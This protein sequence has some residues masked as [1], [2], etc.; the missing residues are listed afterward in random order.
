MELDPRWLQEEILSLP[1]QTALTRIDAALGLASPAPNNTRVKPDGSPG[2]ITAPLLARDSYRDAATALLL[3]PQFDG[4][5]LS[6]LFQQRSQRVRDHPGQ[7]SFPGGKRDPE[8]PSS[9]ATALRELQEETG[10]QLEASRW[11]ARLPKQATYSGFCVTPHV[12]GVPEPLHITENLEEVA[13]SFWLRLSE[14]A[15]PSSHS[16]ESLER[17]QRTI[18]WHVFRCAGRKIIGATAAMLASFFERL[19][20][21]PAGSYA[22]QL[23]R[24]A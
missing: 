6:L 4:A 3:A 9:R 16:I 23:A 17:D 7:I 14:L 21:W 13:E 10:I 11:L 22:E 20:G 19:Y 2:R 24:D 15:K 18:H 1:P 12:F 5:E 8:D